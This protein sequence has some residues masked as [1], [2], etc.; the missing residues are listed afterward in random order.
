MSPTLCATTDVSSWSPTFVPG[1]T[2]SSFEKFRKSGNTALCAMQPASVGF[3]EIKSNKF[4]I[5]RN[6]DF[7][8]L[9]GL[10]SEVH[11]LKQGITFVVKAAK[12]A[13]KHPH[14]RDSIELLFQSAVMLSESSLL[15]ERDGHGS[16]QI[17]AHDLAGFH[18]DE[19][20]RAVDIPRPKL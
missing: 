3:L 17:S 14:D 7:Q 6:D 10:A 13:A 8:R 9:L 2:W 12:V 16:L 19:Q 20:F 5:L 18:E 1:T 4:C 11:R 15:P